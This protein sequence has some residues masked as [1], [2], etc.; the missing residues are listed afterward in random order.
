VLRLQRLTVVL[1]DYPGAATGDVLE[2]EVRRVAAVADGQ[3]VVRRGLDT[4][5][6]GAEGDTAP[7]ALAAG[8][9]PRPVIQRQP[10]KA[11]VG[12]ASLVRLRGLVPS[13]DTRP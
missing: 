3:Q 13:G 2:R 9:C 10:V 12:S 5:E 7:G 11:L 8:R 1:I 6:Q 4:T